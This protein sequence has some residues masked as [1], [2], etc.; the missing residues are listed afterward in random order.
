M[1]KVEEL[2][3]TGY[4]L[5]RGLV[6]VEQEDDQFFSTHQTY[7]VAGRG[8]ISGDVEMHEPT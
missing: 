7:G 6:T 8:G 4:S 1:N 2:N 5:Y 3:G